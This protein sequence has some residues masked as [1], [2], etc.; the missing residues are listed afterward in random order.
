MKIKKLKYLTKKRGL[1]CGRLTTLPSMLGRQFGIIWHSKWHRIQSRL[2]WGYHCTFSIKLAIL[3]QSISAQ[4]TAG[5]HHPWC[6]TEHIFVAN[7][8]HNTFMRRQ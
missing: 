3:N 8:P 4:V 2:R 5:P 6:N 7:V 1:M